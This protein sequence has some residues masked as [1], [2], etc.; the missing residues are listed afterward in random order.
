MSKQSTSKKSTSDHVKHEAKG[1]GTIILV[2]LAAIIILPQLLGGMFNIT[3]GSAADLTKPVPGNARRLEEQRQQNTTPSTISDQ[4]TAA[5]EQAKEQ[6]DQLK[7]IRDAA[8]TA[9]KPADTDGGYWPRLGEAPSGGLLGELPVV[10]GA[11]QGALKA[12]GPGGVKAL[13]P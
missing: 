3:A 4:E 2:G 10:G 5:R 13:N 11:V 7:A 1:W 8:S 6:G 12:L 9:A